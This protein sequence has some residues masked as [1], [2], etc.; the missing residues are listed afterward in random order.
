[1]IVQVGYT[2][3]HLK[4][5]LLYSSKFDGAKIK[6]YVSSNLKVF[7]KLM[8]IHGLTAIDGIYH[9]GTWVYSKDL[10]SKFKMLLKKY[11]GI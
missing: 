2:I 10:S 1:M 5:G 8:V 9:N 11:H 7:K 4:P 3:K 6:Y